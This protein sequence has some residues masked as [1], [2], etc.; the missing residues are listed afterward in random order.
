MYQDYGGIQLQSFGFEA[1]FKLGDSP[2]MESS[3]YGLDCG[4]E[5]VFDSSIKVE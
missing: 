1:N 2:I 5:C 4:L 3:F